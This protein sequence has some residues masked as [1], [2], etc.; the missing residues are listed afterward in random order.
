MDQDQNQYQT[1]NQYQYEVQNQYQAPANVPSY[2][3]VLVWGIIGLAFSCSFYLS[4]LGI[5]FSA[6]GKSKANTYFTYCEYSKQA[7]I[8]NNLAKA[9]LIVGIIFTAL[10]LLFVI[11]LASQVNRSFYF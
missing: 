9:G 5:I 1:Q 8:G 4:F 6:I 3:N 10:F 2:T 11:I 7:K